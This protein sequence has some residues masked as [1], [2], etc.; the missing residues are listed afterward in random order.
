[1]H[2]IWY[3]APRVLIAFALA[4]TVVNAA[5][6]AAAA[7]AAVSLVIVRGMQISSLDSHMQ[8]R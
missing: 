8:W 7:A 2:S 3:M 6:A 5:A 4:L 1:M